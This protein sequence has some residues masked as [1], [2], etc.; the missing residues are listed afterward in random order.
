MDW[1][2]TRPATNANL[3][4]YFNL[5]GVE[6]SVLWGAAYSNSTGPFYSFLTSVSTGGPAY[7]YR[8]GL[9]F[10]SSTV[11]AGT[12]TYSSPKIIIG[13]ETTG[14]TPGNSAMCVGA[15]WNRQLTPAESLQISGDPTGFLT[16][17]GD[18]DLEEMFGGQ[19]TRRGPFLINW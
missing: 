7:L 19:Y 8:N 11:S 14:G 15:M 16:F 3:R 13:C 10:A 1:A 9:F 4:T 18:D 12:I 5:S 2:F 17:P 6:G